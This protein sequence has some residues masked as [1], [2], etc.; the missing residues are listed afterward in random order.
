MS[1][2]GLEIPPQPNVNDPAV[3]DWYRMMRDEH[4]VH[5]DPTT[6][7][8]VV[9][10]YAE[11]RHVLTNP[12]T[13]SSEMH[14]MGFPESGLESLPQMD[15]PRHTRVRQ[16]LGT[17]FTPASIG[18]Y[19][20]EIVRLT[21][22]IVD[23]IGDRDQVDLVADLAYTVPIA[24]ILAILG[25]PGEY[26]QGRNGAA[27]GMA[28]HVM[29]RR[30]QI[31]TLVVAGHVYEDI[32]VGV[33]V[34]GRRECLAGRLDRHVGCRCPAGHR[35]RPPAERLGLRRVVPA[36]GYGFFGGDPCGNTGPQT[37]EVHVGE[38]HDGGRPLVQAVAG[39][40]S[41]DTG[42]GRSSPWLRSE[43]RR[44][45]SHMH[46]WIRVSTNTRKHTVPSPTGPPSR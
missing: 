13:F 36:C 41:A 30:P 40:G 4:P 44:A 43:K 5:R 33:G 20:P 12:G 31:G 42:T 34:G 32:D 24:V 37:R 14:R 39:P 18:A 35:H 8:W 10:R 1:V 45:F 27:H 17:A 25:L 19:E 11:A 15:P 22:E 38:Q 3:Y 16:I 28:Q 7:W 29:L 23:E 46:G 6:G 9:Y 26:L 2:T 21:N